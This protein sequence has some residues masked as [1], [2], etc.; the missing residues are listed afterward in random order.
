MSRPLPLL[1][2]ALA[3]R[4]LSQAISYCPSW[5][6]Q[7]PSNEALAPGSLCPRSAGVTADLS[8]NSFK[9]SL[10]LIEISPIFQLNISYIY[11][12]FS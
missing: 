8:L 6:K 1:P 3:L 11:S 9:L 5:D 7:V 12:I 10:N 2:S 4:L